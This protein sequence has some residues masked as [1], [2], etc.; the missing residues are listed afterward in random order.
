MVLIYYMGVW[1]NKFNEKKKKNEPPQKK[2]K[3]KKKKNLFKDYTK[4]ENVCCM[5]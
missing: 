5:A 2:K 4:Y 3:K 1:K